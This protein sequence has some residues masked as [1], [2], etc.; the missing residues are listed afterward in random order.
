MIDHPIPDNFKFTAPTAEEQ[1]ENLRVA[2]EIFSGIPAKRIR[3]GVDRHRPNTNK[4]EYDDPGFL[5][6]CGSV[7]CVAGWLSAHPYFKDRGLIMDRSDPRFYARPMGALHMGTF[8]FGPRAWDIF[9]SGE[10]GIEGK[11]EGLRRI[12][13]ALHA[14]GAITSERNAELSAYEYSLKR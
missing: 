4:S 6:N 9:Q 7:G 14:S 11:R 8:L 1:I 12:R 2:Y 13:N 10:D 3:L 5:H